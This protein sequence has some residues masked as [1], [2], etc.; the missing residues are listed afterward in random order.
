M[1]TF[2]SSST[3]SRAKYARQRSS[4]TSVHTK[5]FRTRELAKT[6]VNSTSWDVISRFLLFLQVSCLAVSNRSSL[7]TTKGSLIA[8]LLSCLMTGRYCVSVVCGWRRTDLIRGKIHLILGTPLANRDADHIFELYQRQAS[9]GELKLRRY[10]LRNVSTLNIWY[11][12]V[13]SL[14]QHR[15]ITAHLPV[16]CILT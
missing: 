12:V 6:R 2:T 1:T 14:P 15:G 7:E 13:S 16:S 8:S 5:K 9:N 11:S 3:R 10:P 4:G